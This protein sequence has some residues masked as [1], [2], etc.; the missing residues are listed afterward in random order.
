M[1]I[2]AT[3]NTVAAL[4]SPLTLFLF[5]RINP[6]PRNPMPCTMLE[7]ICPLFEL[8][9]PAMIGDRNVNSAAAKQI[10]RFVRTPD[11]LW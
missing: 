5:C 7:A 10:R 2:E 11:G 1:P 9:S 3:A 8:F 4:V 6:A